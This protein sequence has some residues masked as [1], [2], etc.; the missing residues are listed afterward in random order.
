MRRRGDKSYT[1]LSLVEAV[2]EDGKVW[3]RMLLRLGEASALRESGK[4]DRII[5]ALRVHAEGTWLDAS[6][7][8]AAGAVSEMALLFERGDLEVGAS[9][10]E[11][12][13]AT[14]WR[15]RPAASASSGVKRCTHRYTVT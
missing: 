4:L 14:A 6:E 13:V 10:D 3:H 15:H 5:A 11:G 7:L 12:A 8:G 9:E 2:R 1:Y